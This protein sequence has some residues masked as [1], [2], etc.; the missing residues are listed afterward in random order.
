VGLGQEE[1]FQKSLEAGIHMKL[2]K[3]IHFPSLR[4]VITRMS[5]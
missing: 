3:P 2:A 4:E 5:A 1:E